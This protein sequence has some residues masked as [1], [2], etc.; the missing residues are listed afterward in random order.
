LY[1]LDEFIELKETKETV[2]DIAELFLKETEEERVARVLPE[3]YKDYQDVFFKAASDILP[4]Y[5][6]YDHK[7]EF[8]GNNDLKFSPLYGHSSE[9]FKIL[10]QY[11]VDNLSKGFIET[12]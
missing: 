7:I 11:L 1:Q 10:K 12:S 8:T 9:E 2:P 4:P 6:L 3:I 5:R